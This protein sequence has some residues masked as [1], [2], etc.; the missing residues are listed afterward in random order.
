MSNWKN[1]APDASPVRSP[2]DS[3]TMQIGEAGDIDELVERA[4]NSHNDPT[5]CRALAAAVTN[6]RAERD[7]ATSQHE[8]AGE[9]FAE[10][11]RLFQEQGVRDGNR[12]TAAESS[13]AAEK[14]QREEAERQR[15]R[16]RFEPQGDNHHNA[17]KCPYCNPDQV[18]WPVA[19]AAAETQMRAKDE[20]LGHVH[21][22]LVNTPWD[23]KFLDDALAIDAV[24]LDAMNFKATTFAPVTTPPAE[25][26]VAI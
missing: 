12:I 19:L 26:G 21:N 7:W 2:T 14:R 25:T 9:Q 10:L 16:Y 24:V 20:A 1:P 23:R 17:I 18:D 3:V 4:A 15:D 22:W 11:S 8:K 5:L 6:L 13:L